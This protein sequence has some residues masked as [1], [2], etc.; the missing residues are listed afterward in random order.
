M[1]HWLALLMGVLLG[2]VSTLI[3]TWALQRDGYIEI[4]IARGPMHRKQ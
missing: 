4:N 2:I 1:G 3:A